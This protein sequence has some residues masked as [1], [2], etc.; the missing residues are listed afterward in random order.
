LV[1]ITVPV[2]DAL[3]DDE[4]AEDDDDGAEVEAAAPPHAATSSAEASGTPS[5]TATGILASS[6]WII[7]IFASRAV[8]T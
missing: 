5:L 8:V 3:A 6:E 2:V 4:G 7:L 1:V